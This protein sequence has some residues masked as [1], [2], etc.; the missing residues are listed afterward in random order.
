M[1][2][3][4]TIG[5]GRVPAAVARRR[6]IDPSACMAMRMP[7]VRSGRPQDDV[8]GGW[9]RRSTPALTLVLLALAAGCRKEKPDAYGNFE[10]DEVVVSA[11]LGGRLLRFDAAE[12]QRLAAGAEV[13][14]VDTTS[15]ALQ[16]EEITARRGASQARTGEAEAQTGVLVVQLATA[17]REYERTRRLYRAEAAT[18]QQLDRAEGDVR[19]LRERIRAAQAQTG[20]AREEAS[21]AESRLAQVREQIGRSRVVNPIAGTVLATYADA[22]EF[23]QP[24]G[25]LYKIADLDT[26]TLRAYVAGAQLAAVRVGGAVQ[27]RIDTGRKQMATLPGRL[28]WVASEAEFTPTP[29]QTADERTDQ[30]YAVKIRVPNR[31]GMLKI[32]MPGEVII[33]GAHGGGS[34]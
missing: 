31:N 14:L 27:V 12:G 24:G 2:L 3:A 13:A 34:R 29:I 33:P 8:V 7:R 9:R 25:P 26:L 28:S 22:G 10:A 17:E 16:R 32:G 5:I 18:A 1:D 20:T 4:M 15:L 23:V 21:G 30:V 6:A 19:V 11:E